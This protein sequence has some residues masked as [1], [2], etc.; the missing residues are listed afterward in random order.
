MRNLSMK[1]S[2]VKKFVNDCQLVSNQ[3][4]FKCPICLGLVYKPKSCVKCE[5]LLFCSGCLEQMGNKTC[6]YCSGAEFKDI[7]KVLGSLLGKNEVRCWVQSCKKKDLTYEEL[8]SKHAQSHWQKKIKCPLGCNTVLVSEGNHHKTALAHYDKCPNMMI[9]C[10]I[11]CFAHFP[12][13]SS[14]MECVM[15]LLSVIKEKD[16]SL[17]EKDQNMYKLLNLCKEKDQEIDKLK[18]KIERYEKH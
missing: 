10:E 1:D 11:C 4:E 13:Q 7:H 3:E 18:Y 9:N 16:Q 5:N 17:K 8:V 6:P 12:N 15:K 2:D 14:Q